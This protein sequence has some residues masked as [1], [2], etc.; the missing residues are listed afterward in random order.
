MSATSARRLL[1]AQW[2]AP[3]KSF[4]QF[5][6]LT[7]A[8]SPSPAEDQARIEQLIEQACAAERLGFSD[9]WLTE[10][11]FTG[12]SVYNDSL[13]FAAALAMKT[14]KVRIGFA[15]VQT[16]FHHPVRLAVQLA[17]LDN[18]SKGRIDV[19]IG[20]GTV[21]NEYEFVGHG[22]RSH[23]SRARMEE[24][25]DI[26]ERAWRES[27]LTYEG[28]FHKI[29]IPAIRPKPVQQPGP[30]LWRS[31]ISPGSF[32]ECGKLG[33]PILTARLPV[34]RIKERWATYAAGID[35]G[36]H[37]D[38]TKARLLA[39]SALW[40]N[41]YVAD[42]DA[43]AE[44]ELAGLLADTRAHMMH[45]RE[46]YNPHDFQPDPAT[47]NAWTDPKVPDSEAIPFALKTG[48]LYGTAARVREQVA[49][50]RDVGVKHL[51]CQTGFGAM[52][53]ARN[54][55]SMRRFGERVMPAFG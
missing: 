11:Y 16:P 41:V 22:L 32:R 45:V 17:L 49:E 6:W 3:A 50:L 28:K 13:M 47:L 2:R 4:M 8:L 33:V 52:S 23:D 19:G 29:H 55:A 46:A 53:H 35:E 39:Q 12:E 30:P 20:K 26:L 18:L 43:Q 40:R 10:H 51:L 37:D 34:E 15:V 7:L 21:Y 48:S 24:T 1:R 5:G 44:D 25:I 42:S 14:E 38:K 27:P 54:M 31:V 9:V 36:R